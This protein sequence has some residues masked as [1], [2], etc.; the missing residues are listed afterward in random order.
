MNV[1]AK[2]ANEKDLHPERFCTT[3]R[4]LWRVITH[5]GPSPCPKH[6]LRTVPRVVGSHMDIPNLPAIRAALA[7]YPKP[8]AEHPAEDV[9]T[10]AAITRV[11]EAAVHD[12]ATQ[13]EWSAEN[14]VFAV[15]HLRK[16]IREGRRVRATPVTYEDLK[17]YP[18]HATCTARCARCG[19]PAKRQ[20]CLRCDGHRSVTATDTEHPFVRRAIEC[21]DCEGD[22]IVWVCSMDP[23]WCNANPLPGRGIIERNTIEGECTAS[24]AEAK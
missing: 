21:P 23:Q 6:R 8:T 10:E 13:D 11:A 14:F 2:V 5:R 17:N 18:R 24:C 1:A 12:A 7:A 4:C 9:W 22:A 19:V 15:Q 20:T 3:D 16:V